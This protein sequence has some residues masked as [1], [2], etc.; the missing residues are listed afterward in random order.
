[1][2]NG[3]TVL[4]AAANRSQ[5]DVDATRK[6]LMREC[7]LALEPVVVADVAAL[8][9]AIEVSEARTVT[10]IHAGTIVLPGALARLRSVLAAEPGVSMVDAF[11]LPTDEMGGVTG[12]AA[13]RFARALRLHMPASPSGVLPTF[14]RDDLRGANPLWG[15]TIHAAVRRA[16]RHFSARRALRMLPEMLCVQPSRRG[17]VLGAGMR[18]GAGMGRAIYRARTSPVWGPI[19]RWRSPYEL[20]S[21]TVA[22]VVPRHAGRARPAVRPGPIAYVLWRYPMRTETF[23]RREIGALRAAGLPLDVFALEPDDPPM[24]PDPASPSGDVFYFGPPR[25]RA[26]RAA[27]LTLLCRRPWTVLRLA[28]HVVAHRRDDAVKTW[29]GD[30]EFLLLAAQLAAALARRGI[31]HVHSPWG[32]RYATLSMAA[33]W[34]LDATFSVQAR[35]S[36]I[37]RTAESDAVASRLREASFVITNSRYNEQL[38]RRILGEDAPSVHVVYNG[39]ELERFEPPPGDGSREPEGC[40]LLAVG[41]LIEPKGFRYLLEACARLRQRGLSFQCDIIGGTV[42]HDTVTPLELRI[43]MTELA[44]DGVVSFRGPLSFSEVLEA[45]RQADIFV[46]PCVRARDGSHDITPNS[47]IE[48]MAMSLAVVSTRSGAVPEIIDHDRT[49]LLVP[50][51]DAGS[52]ELALE[53]LMADAPLRRRLGR[54]A[55]RTIEDRFDI[56]KN[57]KARM[58]LFTA[59]RPAK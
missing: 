54:A 43:L 52:L 20:L 34:L 57:V 18:I 10:I 15:R 3:I 17:G 22:R 30:R 32:N 29:R 46:L 47:L 40:R 41:R 33:A 23:I 31:A 9:A 24:P 59:D 53:R 16:A 56:A 5:E 11:A 45:Y 42:Y 50:P 27:A 39:V 25:R 48:A 44:L 55:R 49:G 51:A 1:M 28:A 8:R 37:H 14:R 26:G 58:A 13:R 12:D 7:D 36:E 38:L 21:A 35:A 4:I 6:S 2:V 19:R